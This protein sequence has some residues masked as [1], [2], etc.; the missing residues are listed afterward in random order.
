MREYY[1]PQ[2]Q[3]AIKA[4]ASTIMINSGEINGMPVHASKYLL[5]DVLRKELGFQ[6]VDCNRLG[7]YKTFAYDRH[8]VAST[9]GD[10]SCDGDK[11]RH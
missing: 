9:P 1:L 2:F 4:G 7:R 5:T 3:E 10:S 11:C 8:N 6:G